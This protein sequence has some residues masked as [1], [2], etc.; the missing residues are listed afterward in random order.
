MLEQD[1]LVSDM[2]VLVAAPGDIDLYPFSSTFVQNLHPQN[3]YAI[4]VCSSC[5]GLQVTYLTAKHYETLNIFSNYHTNK[6]NFMAMLK[7]FGQIIKVKLK[8]ITLLKTQS[9]NK[10]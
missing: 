2:I 10:D 6:T 7:F 5:T 1:F 3:L 8:W 9:I 4:L